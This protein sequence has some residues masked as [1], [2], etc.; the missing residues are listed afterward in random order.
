MNLRQWARATHKKIT[1]EPAG[2][3]HKDLSTT[4]VEMILR[5]SI[6]V[7]TESL[8]CGA[9]L[10]LR[11]LGRLW[12]EEKAPRQMVSNLPN[13]IR[14]YDLEERRLLRFQ[15]SA[16]LSTAIRSGTAVPDTHI[17]EDR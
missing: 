15:V 11:D 16:K 4:D 8:S 13:H 7:L 1:D 3:R 10:R 12:V 2:L 9:D 5:Q 17:R 6:Q 14:Q